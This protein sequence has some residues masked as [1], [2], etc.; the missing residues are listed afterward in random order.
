MRSVTALVKLFEEKGFTLLRDK[1]H[2]IWACPCGHTQIVSSSTYARG[3]ANDY[4]RIKRTLRECAEL[5]DEGND[6]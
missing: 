1:K 5:T 3:H 4:G 6:A 2:Q